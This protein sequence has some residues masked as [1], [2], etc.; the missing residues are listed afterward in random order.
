MS[1]VKP[2]LEARH[3]GLYRAKWIHFSDIGALL[4][5]SIEFISPNPIFDGVDA[6]A[7]AS[8]Y[9]FLYLLLR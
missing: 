1:A 2:N 6:I 5:I 3:L 7:R 4:N 8:L 9:G